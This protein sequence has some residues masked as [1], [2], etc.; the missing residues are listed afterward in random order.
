MAEIKIYDAGDRIKM[1]ARFSPTD[2]AIIQF[3][4][5]N[6]SADVVTYQ[7][8]LDAEVTRIFEG[9]YCLEY[10]IPS[11]GYWSYKVV[12]T[13]PVAAVETWFFIARS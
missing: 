8:G 2:P 4:L 5:S 7:Y 6:N 3:L 10:D 11:A 12:G 9:Y 13:G 1:Y